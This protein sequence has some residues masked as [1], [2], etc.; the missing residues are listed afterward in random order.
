MLTLRI[1]ST[2]PPTPPSSSPADSEISLPERPPNRL[3]RTLSLTRGDSKPG[4]LFRRLSQRGPNSPDYPHSNE[5][6]IPSTVSPNARASSDS[7]F[8]PQSNLAMN[9]ANGNVPGVSASLPI[10]PINAFHR[11]PTNLSEKAVAKGGLTN[12][13]ISLEYGLDIILNCEVNQRDPAGCTV[14]YRLL[15]PALYYTDHVQ[16][17]DNRVRKESWLS[18]LGSRRVSAAARQG[19]GEWG[20]SSETESETE[21]ESDKENMRYGP[22]RL[23]F[24]RKPRSQQ[25]QHAGVVIGKGTRNAVASQVAGGQPM[26]Q[27]SSTQSEPHHNGRSGGTISRLL[28]TRKSTSPQSAPPQ[29]GHFPIRDKEAFGRQAQLT[30]GG[31]PMSAQSSTSRGDP[32]FDPNG[33]D[34]LTRQ[35]NT[36]QP[37]SPYSAPAHINQF[38]PPRG[39]SAAAARATADS[40][41]ISPQSSVGEETLPRPRRG[42]K[43]DTAGNSKFFG[44]EAEG[45]SARNGNGIV[46]G[47]QRGYGGIEA[48]KGKEKGW[49][50]F[51]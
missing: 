42:S 13:E 38:P 39:S 27:Q 32:Q 1:G 2:P 5:Y 45:P 3:Q 14:P 6:H 9:G 24:L 15:V 43:F 30:G 41:P 4:N 17:L 10:R 35:I 31:Q 36:T 21:S 40:E 11:R 44:A 28:S 33:S 50:K 48:Y 16:D 26:S 20:G 19:A 46:N 34:R 7:Y 25:H 18:R 8:P 23:G 12:G 51:F 47:G 37:L 22:G 29:R 49:K